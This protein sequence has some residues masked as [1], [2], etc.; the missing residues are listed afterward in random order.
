[1]AAAKS[2]NSIEYKV[3]KDEDGLKEPALLEE[4]EKKLYDAFR[5]DLYF[6][7][8]YTVIENNRMRIKLI[9]FEDL[10]ILGAVKEGRLAAAITGHM[11][12]ENRLQLEDLGFTINKHE[13]KISEGLTFYISE[14]LGEGMLA[15]LGSF[16]ETVIAEL[17]K[18]EIT[19]IYSTC[20]GKMLNMYG[21]FDFEA[22]DSR[23]IEDGEE[24]F[25]VKCDLV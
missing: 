22:I 14:D 17:K 25:L 24:E 21:M 10:Y 19:A 15:V 7:K 2:N 13:G 5:D 23:V 16:L 18:R 6:Q 9:P 8:Q 1:M 4:Y 3:I 20:S 11:N 12:M